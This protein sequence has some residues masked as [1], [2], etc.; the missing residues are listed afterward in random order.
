M[1]ATHDGKLSWMELAR[2]LTPLLSAASPKLQQKFCGA[3]GP[4]KL[5]AFIPQQA[6]YVSGKWL[7]KPALRKAVQALKKAVE[8]A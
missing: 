3:D 2:R 7:V 8:A 1:S 5:K 6:G 4:E